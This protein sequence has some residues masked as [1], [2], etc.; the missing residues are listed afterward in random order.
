MAA[1]PPAEPTPTE[2]VVVP[3]SRRGRVL[4]LVARGY[5]QETGALLAD[6]PVSL[7]SIIELFEP[8]A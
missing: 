5:S 8:G 6:A 7:E 1:Q 3:D 2:A 4:D